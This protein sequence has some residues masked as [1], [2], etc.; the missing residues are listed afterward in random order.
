VAAD[1]RLVTFDTR[2]RV[3]GG[4]LV[5]RSMLRFRTRADVDALPAAAGFTDVRW[6]GGWEG[7]PFDAAAGPEIIAAR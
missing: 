4:E 3:D 5:S 1:D 2:F 7:E 6:Y